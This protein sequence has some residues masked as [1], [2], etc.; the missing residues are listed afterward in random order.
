MRPHRTV[1]E[2][3]VARS[4]KRCSVV[5]RYVRKWFIMMG[6]MYLQILS[7]KRLSLRKE[8]LRKR[9]IYVHARWTSATFGK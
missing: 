8:L 4:P 2:R 1:T 3:K 7:A 6:C 9:I 5:T